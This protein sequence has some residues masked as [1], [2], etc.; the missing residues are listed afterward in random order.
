MKYLREELYL[1]SISSEIP[2]EKS[3]VNLKMQCGELRKGITLPGTRRAAENMQ[4]S[5][6]F[7]TGSNVSF[8]GFG[9][10]LIA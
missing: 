4:R 10:E 3:F 6:G 1:S 9:W 8:R 5:C 7:N 2:P